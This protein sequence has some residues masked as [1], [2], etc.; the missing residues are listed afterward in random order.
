[1]ERTSRKISYV[2]KPFARKSF[3]A[4]SLTLAALALGIVSLALSVSMEGNGDLNVAAWAVSS[5]LFAVMALAYG[6][7]SFLEREMNYLLAK[8]AA[9]ISGCL[10]L[11]WICIFIVGVL[12]AA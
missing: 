7:L 9:G 6:L 2:R 8:I 3:V 5:F 10:V 4:L 11:F 12:S 1:M